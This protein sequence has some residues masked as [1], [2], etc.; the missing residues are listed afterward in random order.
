MGMYDIIMVFQKCPYCKTFQIF[1]CQTKD[2]DKQMYVFHPL[3]E[4][5]EDNKAISVVRK[6]FFAGLYIFKD[7]PLDKDCG[8]T[9]QAEFTEARATLSEEFKK[10]EFVEIATTCQSLW[11]YAH[12]RL[13]DKKKNGYISGFGRYFEGK[14]KIKDGK[15]IGKVY[16]II[17]DDQQEY[18]ELKFLEELKH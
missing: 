5:W 7:F 18:D 10:L 8:W 9:D 1:E 16:D 12:A 11:C 3:D 15:L 4:S 17:L 6:D 14:I 2:L 13:H